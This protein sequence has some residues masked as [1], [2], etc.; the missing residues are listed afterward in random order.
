M[1]CRITKMHR[2]MVHLGSRSWYFLPLRC[3][4]YGFLEDPVEELKSALQ[5]NN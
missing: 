3:V 1:S 2:T 5:R 4:K